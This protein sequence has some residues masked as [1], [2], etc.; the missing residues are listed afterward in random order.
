M[1]HYITDI[2]DINFVFIKLL[3]YMHIHLSIDEYYVYRIK[4]Y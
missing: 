2:Y 1:W 4:Q 3:F